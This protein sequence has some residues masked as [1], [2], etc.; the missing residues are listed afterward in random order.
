MRLNSDFVVGAL[1]RRVQDKGAYATIANHGDDS[2]GAI[3]VLVD[4]L[5]GRVA[6]FGPA[7][8]KMDDDPL[9][10]DAALTGNRLFAAVP[11]EPRATRQ[12][13]EDYLARQKRFDA[14][15]WVVDIEDRQMRSFVPVVTG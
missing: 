7:P 6:L 13:A 15:I 9:P 12:A 8:P 4:G 10:D 14:D 2:A 3:F 1:V 5:D 11:L